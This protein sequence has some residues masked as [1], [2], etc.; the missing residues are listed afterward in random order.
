M[1]VL[2]TQIDGS[3]P[4]AYVAVFVVLFLMQWTMR[5]RVA[6]A[7]LEN[8]RMTNRMTAQGYTAWDNVFTGNRYNLRLWLDG[9]KGKLRDG[10]DAQ[11]TA[12]MTKE[13]LSAASGIV[14]L[15]I[16]FAAMAWIAVRNAGDMEVLIALA[17]TLPRQIEMTHDVHTFTSGWNDLLAQLGAPDRRRRQHASG[18]RPGLRRAHEVRPADAARRRQRQ[19]RHLARRRHGPDPRAADRAHQRAR[20]QR[21]GQID[22]ADQPEIGGQDPRLLLADRG[23]AGVR[24][25]AGRRTRSKST[26]TAIRSSRATPRSSAFPPASGNCARCRRSSATPTRRSICSTN[27]TPISI[28]TTAPRPTRWSRSLPGARGWSRFRTGI[29]FE[30]RSEHDVDPPRRAWRALPPAGLAVCRAFAQAFPSRTITIVV[31]YPPGGPIDALARL[32]AQEAAADLKQ[33]IVVENRPGASGIVGTG[34]VARAEPDG[35]TLILG[36]NQT[37]ATNQSLIKNWTFDAVKDFAPVAGVAAM[38]HVLVVRKEFE[39]QERRRRGG[40][41]EG[42]ARRADLRL[43]GQ[44]LGR[45]S[46][47]RAVQDQ[48][49]HRHAACAV[50]GAGADDDRTARRPRRSQHRA[51]AR[52]DRAADRVRQHPRARHRQRAADAQLDTVPTFAEAGV[53]GVEADA[54]SALFAPAKTPPAVIDQLVQGGCGRDGERVR[55]ASL[56]RQ[57]LPVALKTPAEMSAM[58]PGEVAKWAAVIKLANV[59]VE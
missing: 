45:A 31:P 16:V 17:A 37:H 22:A 34:A 43:D 21:L 55:R 32:I 2:G 41:G 24:I 29:G 50:Q 42:Q 52:A 13:G 56:A 33:P 6:G 30:G 58:L 46:R 20:R 12:I 36:T 1:I 47:R 26:R 35:Y 7:Y 28:R 49:R 4:I 8:Q 10:L 48:G 14:G 39:A 19:Q 9:F 53:A 18:R 59:T 57:G 25:R 27:G 23:P 54:W 38:P 11:I 5:K 40:D 3:L 51:A 44:R 15:A